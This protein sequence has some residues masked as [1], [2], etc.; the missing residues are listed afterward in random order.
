MT[1]VDMYKNYVKYGSTPMLKIQEGDAVDLGLT[2]LRNVDIDSDTKEVL[3]YLIGYTTTSTLDSCFNDIIATCG[4]DTLLKFIDNAR[5]QYQEYGKAY[6]TKSLH[7]DISAHLLV[8]YTFVWGGTKEGDA[9]WY[10]VY[11][12]L[13]GG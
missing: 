2:S 1:T 10:A 4:F 11:R 6:D 8:N 7:P 9:Y 3:Q 13:K 5:E 12:K